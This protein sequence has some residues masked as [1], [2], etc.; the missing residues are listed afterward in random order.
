[1]TP[2]A[3]SVYLKFLLAFAIAFA[4]TPILAAYAFPA[5]RWHRVATRTF[6]AC[7]ILV[8]AAGAGH[9]RHWIPKLR[10]LGLDGPGRLR[11]VALGVAVSFALMA[12]LLFV[13]WAL[14]GRGVF[15]GPHKRSFGTDLGRALFTAFNVSI[16]EEILCRGYLK[17]TIGGT[18]SALLYAG[19]HYFR[20][21][22]GTKPAD[23]YDPLLVL[24][25]FPEL[26]EGWTVPHHVTIGLLSLFLFGLALNRLRDRTG[27]L[28]LGMGVHF[29]VV[30][31]LKL[32]T[33]WLERKADGSVFIWGSSR[34][35]DGLVGTIVMALFLLWAYRGRVPA[36]EPPSPETDPHPPT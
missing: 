36:P 33:R 2:A 5:E 30:L 16:I 14:G 29:G 35:H 4:L 8:F 15:D 20:P 32:Y 22:S 24:H 11:R 21:M 12:T 13:E 3:R 19:A 28:Y 27:T 10:A 18:M 9:P 7:V 31:G 34:L 1:M 23:G 6:L 25:R 26:L 17:A